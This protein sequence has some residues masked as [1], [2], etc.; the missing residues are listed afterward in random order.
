V[1]TTTKRTPEQI[2]EERNARRRTR[3]RNESRIHLAACAASQIFQFGNY[4]DDNPVTAE[5]VASKA[6][7]MFGRYA[8][9]QAEPITVEH[10]A[11]AL[12][13]RAKA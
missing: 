1:Q 7:G 12:A 6:N 8:D 5:Q 13:E 11:A 3:R 4:S 2:R 10:A 9:V